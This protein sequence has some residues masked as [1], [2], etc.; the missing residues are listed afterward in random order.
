VTVTQLP[1]TTLQTGT[2]VFGPW[3]LG[4]DDNNCQFWL[5]RTIAGGENS[6]TPDMTLSVRAEFSTDGGTTWPF[7]SSWG[8]FPGGLDHL[9]FDTGLP[10][11]FESFGGSMPPQAGSTPRQVRL[12]TVVVGGPVNIQGNVEIVNQ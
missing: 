12:V 1:L 8:P 3:P 6:K 5:D 2:T 7:V 4:A 10:M 11:T 9:D